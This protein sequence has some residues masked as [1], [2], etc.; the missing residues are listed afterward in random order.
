MQ[1]QA[2]LNQDDLIAALSVFIASRG[3]QMDSTTPPQILGNGTV[4]VNLNS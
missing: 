2:I 3:H 1:I 4:T